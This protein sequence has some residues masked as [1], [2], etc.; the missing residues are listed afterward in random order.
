MTKAKKNRP[1]G[2][3]IAKGAIVVIGTTHSSTAANMK[4][5]KYEE[6]FLGVAVK[7]TRDGLVTE[8]CKQTNAHPYTL[9][10]NQRVIGISD[11]DKQVA[12]KKV[13]EADEGRVFADVETL[14]SAIIAAM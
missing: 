9:D 13:F 3:K 2:M 4:T 10:Y 5:T 7:A 1:V 6:Y 11:A 12:A 8:Y 14:K